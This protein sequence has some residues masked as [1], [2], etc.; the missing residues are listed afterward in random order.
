MKKQNNQKSPFKYNAKEQEEAVNQI[1]T[2]AKA[3]GIKYVLVC[4]EDFFQANC[5]HPELSFTV[6]DAEYYK[7]KV[8]DAIMDTFLEESSNVAMNLRFKKAVSK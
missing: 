7:Q 2:I 5:D 3:N 6:A 8:L 1:D 4:D